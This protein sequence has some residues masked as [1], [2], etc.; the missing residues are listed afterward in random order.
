[1][2]RFQQILV[3]LS[4]GASNSSVFEW[5][6]RIARAAGSA[7]LDFVL[8]DPEPAEWVAEFPAPAGNN[9]GD[10]RFKAMQ[11]EIATRFSGLG[12]QLETRIGVGSALPTILNEVADGASD[13][14]VIGVAN[15]ED[16]R[17]AEKVTRKSPASVLTVPEGA[18]ARCHSILTPVDFST[19][20]SL[21]L[22]ITGAFATGLEVEKVT[23]LHSFHISNNSIP[24]GV[25][26]EQLHEDYLRVSS[27]ELDE[28]VKTSPAGS[29][30]THTIVREAGLPS[31]AVLDELAAGDYDLVVMGTRGGSSIVKALLGS[32][33]A[34]VL[35]RSPVPVLAVKVKGEGL[36]ILRAILEE[37]QKP[38]PNP[39][40]SS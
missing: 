4:P 25:T 38:A 23:C 11:E 15:E 40:L 5:T 28:F 21:A 7:R 27:S 14:V 16:R 13:L 31:R 17:L 30:Q 9:P 32:N 36:P 8:L 29:L 19:P 2:K 12:A 3:A 20:S 37:I 39:A 35:R 34:E 18:T 10:E 26:P 33:T 24:P 22:D 6:H 1:M